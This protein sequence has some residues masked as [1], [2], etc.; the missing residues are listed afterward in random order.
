MSRESKR[1]IGPK[2]V[3]M[4]KESQLGLSILLGAKSR[5]LT[6]QPYMYGSFTNVKEQ[7]KEGEFVVGH[8]TSL[9]I[10]KPKYTQL[11]CEERPMI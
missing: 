8:I 1:L 2:R 9:R 6:I 4:I 10:M 3:K 7:P 5:L 11:L